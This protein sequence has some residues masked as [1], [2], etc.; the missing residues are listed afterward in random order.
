MSPKNENSVPKWCYAR[1][2]HVDHGHED[3]KRHQIDFV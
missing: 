2:M 1:V 3:E